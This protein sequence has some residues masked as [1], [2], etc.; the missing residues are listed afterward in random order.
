[1]GDNIPV[2]A[3]DNLGLRN[4]Q[5]EYP[6]IEILRF[7]VVVDGTEYRDTNETDALWLVERFRREKVPAQS[8]SLIKGELIEAVR[9]KIGNHDLLVHVIMGSMLSQATFSVAE[10][11]KQQFQDKI[12]ILNV[13]SKQASCGVGVVLLRVLQALEETSDPDEIEKKSEEI[14]ANTFT[15]IAV[16]DLGYLERGGRIGKARALMGSVLNIIPI[17]GLLGDNPEG[18]IV[19]LGKGRTYAQ[20]NSFIVDFIRNKM[21]EKGSNGVKLVN[22][23]ELDADPDAVA[24][25]KENVLNEIPVEKLIEGDPRLVEAVHLGPGSYGLSFGLA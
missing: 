23:V 13:D 5:I 25:L 22:L 15:A 7:P 24:H 8:A 18:Q 21:R 16:P 20:V 11:V 1:M 14:V 3:G 10:D 9:K 17:I 6:D 4:D 19:P 2:I 12:R